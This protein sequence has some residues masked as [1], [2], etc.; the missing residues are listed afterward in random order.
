MKDKLTSYLLFSFAIVLIYTV[1]EFTVSTWTGISHDTVTTCVFAFFGTEIGACAFIKIA[2]RK[3]KTEVEVKEEWDN[4][5]VNEIDE[6]EA[7]G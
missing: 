2:G 5:D 6:D 3:D 1:V 4:L 7:V